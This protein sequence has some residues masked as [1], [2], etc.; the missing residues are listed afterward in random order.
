M[1]ENLPF[2]FPKDVQA[3]NNP[4]FS[5]V[6][7]SLPHPTSY[8]ILPSCTPSELPPICWVG[9]AWFMNHLIKSSRSSD[10]LGGI[11]LTP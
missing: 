7:S 11:L 5:L 3:K 9:C 8:A 10:V 2:L 6:N 4:F 1:M